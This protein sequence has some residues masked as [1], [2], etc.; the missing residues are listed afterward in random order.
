MNEQGAFI[1]TLLDASRKAFAAGTV[2]RLQE[3]GEE[4]AAHVRTW[5]FTAVV[6]DVQERLQHLAEA[7]ACGR[8]ELFALDAGWL[9]ATYEARGASRAPL[10]AVLEAL[11]DE[12]AEG[13][14]MDAAKTA[15]AYLEAGLE[16][17]AAPDAPPPKLLGSEGPHVDSALRFLEALLSG[18]RAKAE[19]VVFEALDGGMG[20]G[21]LHHHVITRAQAEVGHMWQR[22]EIHVADEHLGSRIVEDVLALVR[23]RTAREPR[24]GKSVLVTSV[25]GNLH[26]IGARIVADHFEMCG[27]RAVFLGANT[28]TEDLLLAVRD[29][30]PDLV[31]ISAGT[32]SYVRET[33]AAIE[34][35]KR[36][37]ADLPVLVG[38]KLF[39]VVPELWRDV[40]ADGC[41][42]DAAQAV[43]R[44]TQLVR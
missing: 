44:A 2:L 5:G 38:G 30:R 24:N 1:A 39:A 12:L 6:E 19:R 14:P 21:D 25:A 11:C 18:E 15:V 22:G 23:A 16:R 13:L 10:T 8:K 7:L 9:A 40:G 31:A 41:A 37:R 36:E 35:L 27:W 3:S 4:G 29:H 28:P 32:T 42:A 20:F 43:E 33:A 17:L 34:A 26:D